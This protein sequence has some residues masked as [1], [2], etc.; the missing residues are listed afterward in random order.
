MDLSEDI[1]QDKSHTS[2]WIESDKNY[3]SNYKINKEKKEIFLNSSND[4]SELIQSYNNTQLKNISIVFGFPN[5]MNSYKYKR[6]FQIGEYPLFEQRNTFYYDK[7]FQ[8]FKNKSVSKYGE[9]KLK[10]N[11]LSQ[12]L[13]QSRIFSPQHKII[14]SIKKRKYLDENEPQDSKNQKSHSKEKDIYELEI[15]NQVI[16]NENEEDGKSKKRD[17]KNSS[18]E[19]K[20]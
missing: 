8:L 12:S 18:K 10:N 20:E 17:G 9:G 7:D 19:L 2:E 1:K 16:F 14:T 13:P 11:Y 3:L 4:Y 5:T 6:S 15:I